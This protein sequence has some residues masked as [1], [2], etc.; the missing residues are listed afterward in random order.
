MEVEIL[1]WFRAKGHSAINRLMNLLHLYEILTEDEK[2][3]VDVLRGMVKTRIP[4]CKEK[5]SFGVPFFYRNKGICI[6]WPASVPRGGFKQGVLLG[7]WNGKLLNDH[8]G[9]LTKGTNKKVY[10]KIYRSYEE[11]DEDRVNELLDEAVEIDNLVKIQG[12]TV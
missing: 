7:F 11:I 8:H 4:D 9:Y 1:S 5:F 10:Y 2:I 12:K 3:M 6:I